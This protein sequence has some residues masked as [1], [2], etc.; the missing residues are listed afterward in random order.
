[1]PSQVDDKARAHVCVDDLLVRPVDVL[2]ADQC[3]IRLDV[4]GRAVVD[5]FLSLGDATDHSTARASAVARVWIETAFM[6]YLLRLLR[7][8]KTELVLRLLR[9]EALDTVF[10]ESQA[11]AHEVESCF[12]TTLRVY[13]VALESPRLCNLSHSSACGGGIITCGIGRR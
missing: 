1:M 12:S 10:R 9:G 3:N 13:R 4:P 2:G 7:T 6:T 8:Q 11:P 5:D